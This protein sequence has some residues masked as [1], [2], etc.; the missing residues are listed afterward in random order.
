[1]ITRRTFL[2]SSAAA[3]LATA[4]FK[5]KPI[6]LE[7]YS[8]RGDLKKDL[9]GTVKAVAKMGY[10]GVEFYSPYMEWTPDY[11]KEVRKLMDDS[12]IRCFSTHNSRSA[13]DSANINKAMDLN[14][15]IGSRYIV[16]ASAGR[17]ADLD[18][19]KKVAD[20]LNE[21]SL[22]LKSAKMR[23]GFHNHALEFKPID[24]TKPMEV[25]AKN[26]NKDVVLQ[27]DIGTCIEAGTDPVAW[28]NQNPGRIVSMHCKEWSKTKG[29][30]ALFGEGE[31]DWKAIFAAAEKGGGIEYYLIEQEGSDYSEL[32]TAERCL[33]NIKKTRA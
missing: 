22:K 14:G 31:A 11:A 16:M 12:G 2:A 6:G 19:W 21:G 9:M 27:L 32:E 30:R 23:S 3:P 7:L 8:V 5:K 28:I 1:M 26:T 10:Q 4:A 24:G 33:A 13:F 17:V 29:Y 20:T 18:G 25:L 15:I